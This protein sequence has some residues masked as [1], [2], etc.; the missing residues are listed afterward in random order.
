MTEYT[1]T[2]LDTPSIQNYIFGSNR[3]R[4]NIGASELVWRAT[5][6]WPLETLQGEERTNVADPS[7]RDPAQ[8][9]NDLQI[10]RDD[11]D[12]EV[13]YV[14][15][16][17]AL[18][19]FAK[20][21]QARDFVTELHSR[22]LQE[23]PG[24][25]LAAA[26]IVVD[27]EHHHL[28]DKVAEVMQKLSRHKQS[29]PP[30]TP[31]LGQSVTAECRSTGLVATTTNAAHGKPPNEETYPISSSVAAKLETAEDAEQRLWNLTSEDFRR[32]KYNFPRDF[33]DF[34]RTK[35]EMSYIAVV[36]A[37]GNGMGAFFRRIAQSAKDS[38]SYVTK[39]RT[40]SM[41]VE[42]ASQ[43]ALR[44]LVDALVG[45]VGYDDH[46]QLVVGDVVPLQGDYLP[47]RPLVFG[48]DDVTF[49]C[50]GR[51]G[52]SLGARYLE[53]FEEETAK[54]DLDDLHACA[55]VAVVKAHY[56]FARA[57]QLSERLVGNAKAH[58]R[59]GQ[60][61]DFSALDWH[62]AASGLLGDI[63][64]DIRPRQYAV[65]SNGGQGKLYI[66]PVRLKPY[67]TDWRTW[68]NFLSVLRT[69]KT[70]WETRRNKALALREVLREGPEAVRRF[71][72][73]TGQELPVL[74]KS[75]D[76]LQKTGWFGDTCGYFDAIEALDFY[77]PL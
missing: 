29:S 26:H 2:I 48:G 74:D 8:R 22:L 13:L 17:N 12:A 69:F 42:Q 36:H 25:N 59:E 54:L 58:V 40:A 32:T 53:L 63:Q 47:F 66:R 77:V 52:L 72:T 30:H 1:L 56:P 16:G 57:Y 10:E 62:F 41:Q 71:L 38:R 24:L 3:L 65:P 21:A 46:G 45:A 44:R 6:R 61:E 7:A 35:G 60:P 43:A 27:W 11:L 14:G 31:L 37:D 19:L 70:Q 67:S 51:L 18:I 64:D 50:D 34:G 68:P 5:A 20:A 49:V 23:T 9:L 28:R 76:A 15:G 55:G 73:A 4:E 33:D 75:K 39:M